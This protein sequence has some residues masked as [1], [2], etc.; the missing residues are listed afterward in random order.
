MGE[1]YLAEHR[2]IARRA[3][4]KVLRAEQSVR[5]DVVQRFFTEAR[6]ASVIKHPGIVEI[7]DCDV[8]VRGRAYIV[9]E[10]LEGE[11][12][13]SLLYR[14]GGHT[15]DPRMAVAI[16][17]DLASALAAAHAE[18]IV[19]R[20]LKPAN[21]FMAVDDSVRPPLRVK[22]LDFGIAKLATPQRGVNTRTG[23]LLGTPVYMSPEQCRGAGEVD[24]RS[25]IYSLGCIAFE[26]VCGRPP[27]VREGQ[28]ELILAHATEAPPLLSSIDPAIGGSYERH[29]LRMLAKDPAARPQS[30]N[31]VI[32][33]FDQTLREFEP[34]LERTVLLERGM[35]PAPLEVLR[36]A[37]RPVDL[38]L[39][40]GYPNVAPPGYPSVAPPGYPNYSH[41][42]P[43]PGAPPNLSSHGYPGG[44][45]NLSRNPDPGA[46]FT[47]HYA[48]QSSTTLGDTASQ[49]VF[50]D[51]E[52]RAASGGG[53]RRFLTAVVVVAV[54]IFAF[55]ALRPAAW[56]EVTGQLPRLDVPSPELSAVPP[57]PIEAVPVEPTAPAAPVELPPPAAPLEVSVT[58]DSEP[59]GAAVWLDDDGKSRGV[60]P[61][62]LV[63]PASRVARKLSLRRDGYRISS[64][65]LLPNENRSISLA[66]VPL[67]A[68]PRPPR[69]SVRPPP[70]LPPPPSE[71]PA[72]APYLKI[73]D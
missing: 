60:T 14:A 52:P 49:L 11:S 63:L 37:I 2:N 29:V 30:M 16:V 46:G 54:A 15:R 44:P 5:Q 25:D 34:P 26:L 27:F 20:D 53:F 18:R 71:A 35:P 1:V 40:P 12:L 33:M 10:L 73:T 57:P 13:E 45:T 3:A 67:R 50:H 23:S 59:R 47:R 42:F 48:V 72:R 17:R 58:I 39:P 31:E 38:S 69:R 8:D 62:S 70:S 21:I 28:G 56:Q 55:R 66:L 36:S 61:L 4:I 51:P 7:I 68:A 64:M 22:I 43:P 32:A 9:M 41:N 6:A 24:H 19:H 65:S